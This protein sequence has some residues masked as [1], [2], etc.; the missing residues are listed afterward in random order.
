MTDVQSMILGL[1][2]GKEI[3]GYLSIRNAKGQLIAEFQKSLNKTI[4]LGLPKGEY[5][6]HL[7][8]GIQNLKAT[9][10]VGGNKIFK[11]QKA[12]FK[13]SSPFLN[14]IKGKSKKNNIAILPFLAK[15]ADPEE[16]SIVYDLFRNEFVKKSGYSVL[17]RESMVELL[18]EKNLQD[19]G[20]LD[21]TCI[22]EIGKVLSM[23]YI[24]YGTL[25]FIGENYYLTIEMVNIETSEVFQ[26]EKVKF[27]TL[28]KIDRALKYITRKFYKHRKK[29]NKN[30]K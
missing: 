12:D 6:A 11:L 15:A 22:V 3:N 13:V 30:K 28:K 1:K 18:K 7:K 25:L 2:I 5:S 29:K 10:E 9:F 20:C 24:L 27:K 16:A 4:S 19:T 21:M 23:Q 26:S 8:K 17:Q 14:K